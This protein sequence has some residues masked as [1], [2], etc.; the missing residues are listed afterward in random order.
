M[1]DNIV[2]IGG[3]SDDF[4]ITYNKYKK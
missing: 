4:C 2:I 1:N 3:N